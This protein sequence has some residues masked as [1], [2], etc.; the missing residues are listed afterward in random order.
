MERFITS[1]SSMNMETFYRVHVNTL[2]N[3]A[4][5]VCYGPWCIDNPDEGEYKC[6]QDLPDWVQGRIAVLMTVN[7]GEKIPAIG[8]RTTDN[9]FHITKPIDGEV[10]ADE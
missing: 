6:L 8:W 5:V 7:T 10:E 9:V 2:F 4:T 1:M 3:S